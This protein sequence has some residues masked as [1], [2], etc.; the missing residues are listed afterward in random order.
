[1]R[2][3]AK[4]CGP[5]GQDLAFVFGEHQQ[6]G[7][8]AQ[9]TERV[10]G[11]GSTSG[12]VQGEPWLPRSFERIFHDLDE[13]ERVVIRWRDFTSCSVLVPELPS[14]E[15]H[16]RLNVD[17]SDIEVAAVLLVQRSH[18]LLRRQRSVQGRCPC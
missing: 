1:M 4:A 16:E 13:K 11:R 12:R 2:R 17:R 9:G 14:L 7:V 15:V 10:P 8:L 5:N 18:R 6:Q 3:C